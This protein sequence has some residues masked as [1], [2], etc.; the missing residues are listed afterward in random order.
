MRM[1]LLCLDA[2]ENP[3]CHN[4]T[5]IACIFDEMDL[6]DLH[7]HRH[8]NQCHP[9]TY[10]QGTKPINICA[11]SIKFAEAL[12]AAWYLPFGKP[13][14]LK[15]DHHTLGLDSNVSLLFWQQASPAMRGI[16]S[17]NTKL[18]QKFCKYAIQECQQANI[19][20][21][22]QALTNIND[23]TSEDWHAL[24]TIDRDITHPHHSGQKMHQTRQLT[25]VATTPWSLCYPP[26]L[27]LKTQP[28]LYRV[29]LPTCF[30]EI[31]K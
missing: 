12:I 31:R 10:N 18:T 17:N 1:L 7:S 3:Q 4:S 25:T 20:G 16:N 13:F 23:L 24:K 29:Q 8:P 26:L 30:L 28:I 14:G 9:P 5:G 11:G 6:I 19:Y 27:V 22:I 2:N 21:R 15:G